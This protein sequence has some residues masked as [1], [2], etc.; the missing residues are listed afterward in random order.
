MAHGPTRAESLSEQQWDEEFF[1]LY[2]KN[3]LD[4]VLDEGEAEGDAGQHDGYAVPAELLQS[5]QMPMAA[6]AGLPPTPPDASAR[7]KRAAPRSQRATK[8]KRPRVDE[9]SPNATQ[10]QVM[11]HATTPPPVMLGPGGEFVGVVSAVA[12]Q[13]EHPLLRC[14][15]QQGNADREDTDGFMWLRANDRTTWLYLEVSLPVTCVRA[16]AQHQCCN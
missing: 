13:P 16:P 7:K 9:V 8:S 4:D 3:V 10:L 2:G 12:A 15:I 5:Q 1:Q 6:T 11:A 14:D